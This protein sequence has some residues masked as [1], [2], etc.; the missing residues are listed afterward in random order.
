[1]TNT[2]FFLLTFLAVL[3]AI[4]FGVF[5]GIAIAERRR[6]TTAVVVNEQLEGVRR[7]AFARLDRT[8]RAAVRRGDVLAAEVI[9]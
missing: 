6:Q 5:V 7:G 2:E 3:A 9:E 1:M 4:V 8:R